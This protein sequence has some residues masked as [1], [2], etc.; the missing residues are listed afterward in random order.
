[1]IPSCE[2]E[3]IKWPCWSK[4]SPF[5]T[6]LPP[7]VFVQ[8]V[9]KSSHLF[10][11]NGR[12]NRKEW[13][14]LAT[15]TF[16]E[17]VWILCGCKVVPINEKS[18]AYANKALCMP[19]SPGISPA[20]RIH[21]WRSGEPWLSS[22][23][24]CGCMGFIWTA[25]GLLIR[26]KTTAGTLFFLLAGSVL[27][28][29]ASMPASVGRSSGSG[30]AGMDFW[31]SKPVCGCWY[32][33]V[34]WKIISVCW[35]ACTW[36]TDA[37]IPL[38]RVAVL[39]KISWRQSPNR[40]K[41]QCMACS[42]CLGE[43]SFR[44]AAKACAIKWPPYN[45]FQPMSSGWPKYWLGETVCSCNNCKRLCAGFIGVVSA[46]CWHEW[47]YPIQTNPTKNEFEIN[48]FRRQ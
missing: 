28:N 16:G 18:E 25:C 40:R 22:K 6:P 41:W 38:R 24:F 9:E 4:K 31:Y 45:L 20:I 42:C 26:S 29:A 17:S 33:A 2:H 11:L 36:I 15:L 47:E 7:N 30:T 3:A 23:K 19:C 8:W 46:W 37:L 12:K 27:T 21:I 39:Y 32:E 48:L 5:T 14:R 1:M 10:I 13:S 34:R 43:A 44:L 35:N